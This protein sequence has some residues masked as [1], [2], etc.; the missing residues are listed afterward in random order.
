MA[1]TWGGLIVGLSQVCYT[2]R[3]SLLDL[4]VQ[5]I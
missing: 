2:G 5:C 3:D 4:L 1:A